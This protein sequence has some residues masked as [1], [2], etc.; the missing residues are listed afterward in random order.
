MA[1]AKIL[2]LTRQNMS[3]YTNCT[4]G[5]DTK[6]NYWVEPTW[7]LNDSVRI[8]RDDWNGDRCIGTKGSVY[9]LDQQWAIT[10]S[11]GDGVAIRRINDNGSITRVFGVSNGNGYNHHNSLA[12]HEGLGLIFVSQYNTSRMGVI[13]IS[14]WIAAGKPDNGT[15][16]VKTDNIYYNDSTWN[17]PTDR[18]GTSY[19]NGLCIVGDWLYMATYAR[20]SI[21]GV[22]RW[23]VITHQHEIVSIANNTRTSSSWE[24]TFTYDST[25]D[26][27]WFQVRW[28]GGL[29]K[30]ESASSANPN[31]Y[32]ISY[33]GNGD[34]RD[35]RHKGVI[36]VD[37]DTNR[38]I[39]GGDNRILELD[40]TNC[41]ATSS[42]AVVVRTSLTTTGI[43]NLPQ[44]HGIGSDDPYNLNE[45]K[46]GNAYGSNFINIYSDRGHLRKGGWLN[47]DTLAPVGRNGENDY[48]H[49]ND[50]WFTDYTGG[51]YK[52]TSA[53]G[54]H[55]WGGF[56]YGWDGHAVNVYPNPYLLKDNYTL[57]FGGGSSAS[58]DDNS[59]ISA[60]DLS[61]GYDL[62]V[63]SGCT[64]ST[65]VSNNNGSTYEN[66]TSGIH[67]FSS[68]G[69][70]IRVRYIFTGLEYKMPYLTSLGLPIAYIYAAGFEHSSSAKTLNYKISGI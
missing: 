22:Y 7:Q 6:G 67:V 55:Y 8:T 62:N 26:V 14:A 41:S 58:F 49:S 43:N 59:P 32:I 37:G 18:V 46:G 63:P 31:A 29:N 17:F 33:T 21:S 10:V 42:E 27:L 9:I 2:P 3:S 40:I 38:I 35:V 60:L 1:I 54:T 44:Y 47:L 36:Y 25:N 11:W 56:G 69:N 70:K 24:G 4:L 48:S 50:T 12:V 51:V 39:T 5:S 66:F 30:I 61:G 53:N 64:V 13:D 23:N 19:E 28:D 16:I 57:T 68:T 34:S 65:Q 45:Y 15:G 20:N 52:M